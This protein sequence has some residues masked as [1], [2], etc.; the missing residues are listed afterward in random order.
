MK[1]WLF[2][3]VSGSGTAAPGHSADRVMSIESLE[4]IV[5]NR[6]R[7]ILRHTGLVAVIGT[8]VVISG[9]WAAF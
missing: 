4:H 2:R 3:R 8:L 6:M 1:F 9:V 7:M 5:R